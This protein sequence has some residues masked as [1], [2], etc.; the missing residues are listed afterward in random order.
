M[1]LR[2]LLC[3]INFKF[4]EFKTVR[5]SPFQLK[6]TS[7][8]AMGSAV[9]ANCKRGKID[10]VQPIHAN[11]AISYD[12]ETNQLDTQRFVNEECFQFHHLIDTG[13][14]GFVFKATKKTTGISY[15]LKVQPC[16]FMARLTRAGNRRVNEESLQMEKTTLIAARNNPFI[17]Q[18][19]Y[20]FTTP[21]YAVLALEYVPGGTLSRLISQS[22]KARLSV[23]LARIYT[24]EIALALHFL[25]EKGFIYRDTKPSNI[26]IGLDG[27]TKL[28]DFGLAGS[29]VE[30]KHF[31]VSTN[32]VDSNDSQL[33]DNESTSSEEPEISEDETTYGRVQRDLRRVRRRTLCGTAGFRP[34]EQVGER[35]I[36]YS[37]RSGYDERAD[38]FSLGV[39]VFT[40]VCGRRPFPSK[41]EM[42][43]S[44]VSS[45]AKRRSSINTGSSAVE[46]AAIRKVMKDVEW[47]CL[48]TEVSYPRF[49]SQHP[50][51]KSFMEQLLERNPNTRPRFDGIRSHPWMGGVEFDA[52]KLKATTIPDFHFVQ[53]HALTESKSSPKSMRRYSM[54]M[55]S[56]HH[57]S[58]EEVSLSIF[59]KDICLQM[60]EI[61]NKEEAE[62]A[63]ARWMASPSDNTKALFRTWEYVSE[64]AQELERNA[65]V[66]N[67]NQSSI[68][69][70]SSWQSRFTNRLPTR[71]VTQ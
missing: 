67:P 44:G 11:N 28:T 2:S 71:R 20:A 54:A 5:L 38:F 55:T 64:D 50:E 70:I 32:S 9:S 39:T 3:S 30:K 41:K 7:S 22:P 17:V 42:M 65:V 49:L 26:L 48:M 15:A 29:L 47:K 10:V 18:L 66:D 53:R 16:E 19:E 23:D 6:L 52:E 58:K 62:N 33:S 59:I 4:G 45:P 61:G 35:Y 1:F 43:Q 24:A 34:P 57:K 36:D 68:S 25:H 60:M 46:R 51:A 31:V 56:L 69:I 37:N 63:A 21:L 13:G 12:T 27:H 40:M 8:T 14:F